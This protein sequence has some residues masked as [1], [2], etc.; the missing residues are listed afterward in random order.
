M[1][2]IFVVGTAA[3]TAAG[4]LTASVAT[5]EEPQPVSLG[6]GGYFGG[7]A[8]IS[9]H[10]DSPDFLAKLEPE[11]SVEADMD[12][13]MT[14]SATLVAEI[15][16]SEVDVFERTVSASG[17]FGEFRFGH[18]KGARR[19]MA[20]TSPGAT[21]N[22]G[23]ND[24]FFE[25]I[26]S[27]AATNGSG[28]GIPSRDTKLVWMSPMFS[29]A[30]LGLSY[31]PDGQVDPEPDGD[32]AANEQIAAAI[33][34][35]PELGDI[36]VSLNFGY[37]TADIDGVDVEEF[38]GGMELAIDQITFGG[39]LRASTDAGGADTTEIDIGATVAM[40]DVTLGIGWGGTETTDMYAA[41]ASY[42]L[43]ENVALEAQL[44]TTDDGTE[45]QVQL[46]VGAAFSF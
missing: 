18:T 35:S 22:F 25:G 29:M 36:G 10:E 13:G 8:S 34:F 38:N 46:L 6:F 1:R 31:A 12:N 16:T 45:E 23:V 24:P 42:P 43:S 9:E 3:A 20:I 41:G 40:G 7:A 17:E 5:A 26:A 44:D 14:F 11:V 32:P 30:Q 4:L 33:T 21:E 2:R 19:A 28:V 27:P 39:G 37:E 15:D